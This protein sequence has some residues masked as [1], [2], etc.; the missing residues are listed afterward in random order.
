MENQN[1]KRTEQE[2]VRIGKMEQ[3]KSQNVEPFGE[4]FDKTIDTYSL[5]EKYNIFEKEQLADSPVEVTVAG[6]IMTKRGK[7][8]AGFC[9]LQ[10]QT[11]QVQLYIRADSV[12]E[13]EYDLFQKADLGDIVGVTGQVFKTKVGELSIR[14]SKFVH[15]SKALRP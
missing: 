7:G 4:R 8:K 12:S 15:L 1:N 9:H 10:D 13:Q 6:R 11:G 5:H 2:L 14:V 3:L